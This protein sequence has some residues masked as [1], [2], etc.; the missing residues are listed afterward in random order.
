MRKWPAATFVPGNR[1]SNEP[2]QDPLHEPVAFAGN[3]PGDQC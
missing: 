2:P 3:L 1:S